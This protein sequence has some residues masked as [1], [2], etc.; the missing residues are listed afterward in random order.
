MENSIQTEITSGQTGLLQ[1]EHKKTI[2]EI[3]YGKPGF[4]RTHNKQKQG[5]IAPQK[6]PP[7]AALFVAQGG[8]P[9]LT[10]S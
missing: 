3:I 5:N 10:Q 8:E 1:S 6:A 9:M 4:S 2:Q 7:A